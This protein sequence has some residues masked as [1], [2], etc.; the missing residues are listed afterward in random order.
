VSAPGCSSCGAQNRPDRRFCAQCGAPLELKCP[1]CGASNEHDERFCGDC[2]KP[3]ASNGPAPAPA[4]QT[5]VS[6]RRLVSVLF[7]DLVSFTTL[8][9][10]RDPEAVREL[11]SLYFDRCRTLI[12]RYGGT[13]E[14]FIGDAVMAV[15][16]TPV[17]REDDPER[18][19]RA[20]L[21][22][23]KAVTAL[24]AEVGMPELRV[25]AG[26]LTGEAAVQFGTTSEGMVLGDTVNTASRLQSIA[27][28]A[29]VLVDDVTRRVTEASIAYEDTG[30]HELKGRE[31]PVHAWTALRVVAAVG[32]A[33][34][35][36]GLE[37]PFVGRDHELA[38]IT[39]ASEASA[40]ERRAVR[41]LVVGGAGAG[42]SRLLWEYF[43]HLDGIQDDYYWHQGRCLAYG[44]GVGYWALAEMV[45]SRAGILEEEE[46]D[47]ARAKLREC[48]EQHIQDDRERRLVEPRLAHLLGLEQRTAS[49][50]ADLFSGWRLFFERLASQDP[51]VLV[52]EDLH[53]ADSGLLD[54]IDYLLEW[55]TDFPIFILGLGRTELLSARP[56]WEPTVSLGA[57]PEDAMARLLAGLVPGLPEELAADVRSRSEG[58]PL[59]AVETVRMLLDRGLV[60]QEGSRYIITGD[61][62]DLQV[63]ESLHALVAARLDNLEPAE[64]SLLQDASVIGNSFSLAQLAAISRHPEEDVQPLLESLVSKQ[65]L[66]FSDDPHSTTR[67]HYIFLQALLR[68]ITQGTLS[69]RDRK[70]RHLAVARHI[71]AVS[72]DEPAELA[73]VLASHYVAAVNADPDAPDADELRGLASQ[74]LADAGRRALSLA[75]GPEARRHFEQAAELA[76]E[77]A[78]QGRLVDEA[79]TA[80]R[81]TDAPADSLELSA[82]AVG[83]LRTAG[84]DR[85][86]ARAE[87]RA[88]LTLQ[89]L[90][91]VDEAAERMARAYELVDDG[92][93]D[94]AMADL[95]QGRASIEFARGNLEDA[96]A[97]TDTALRIADGRRLVAILVSA[98][99]T[100]GITLAELGRPNESTALLRHA[101]KL[102]T[103]QGLTAEVGHAF[104]NLADT[105]MTEGRFAEAHHLLKESLE[106]ARTRGDRS[107]ERTLL[108]QDQ[109]ALAAL[110]RWDDAL[111]EA[112]QLAEQG[113]DI[114]S[115]HA[116]VTMPPVLAARGDVAGLEALMQQI[117]PDTGWRAF[118]NMKAMARAAIQR[119]TA[120]GDSSALGEACEAALRLVSLHTSEFPPLFAEVIECAFAAG[121]PERVEQLL[122]AVDEL[123]PGQRGPLLEAEAA[124]ARARLA[125]H[126][127]DRESADDHYTRAIALFSELETPFYL[128]RAQLEFAELLTDAAGESAAGTELRQQAEAVFERLGARPWLDRAQR[129]GRGIPA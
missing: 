27:A 104:Y 112:A 92:T 11:L 114:W 47:V 45:R 107:A 90:G 123:E 8:S 113:D 10:H 4:T 115:A 126:N 78:L 58:V 15:W 122:R 108:A 63:P 82:T 50:L 121:E 75:L 38:A 118:E 68:T 31:Q 6:E 30:L 85:E 86:A 7:A 17:A 96:L 119:V 72:G 124:R 59:Y 105:V 26:V 94:E 56:D 48:I 117:G 110:A 1:S 20:A 18:A 49:D 3:L 39:N 62:S 51:V 76:A 13:V 14:K 111:R 125:A 73:E 55:S 5:G 19:V 80:T 35:S 128:A 57:L 98:L 109:S 64:R 120:P 33:R 100:K 95:A 42:K 34:R 65:V 53:W 36:V 89:D 84:L 103:D 67:G 88:A 69:R 116:I 23:T 37:A 43:K 127:S 70:A 44:D 21:A 129:L 22:L 32:G 25:R 93:D 52:F 79:A 74:T 101:A 99:I 24:G 97:L 29:T 102:A 81:L 66:G 54:F 71:Q 9:E 77:P 12:N 91:R 87:G 83:L 41:V 16:G 40:S 2:G 28:P 61:V 46:P 106:L 60:A